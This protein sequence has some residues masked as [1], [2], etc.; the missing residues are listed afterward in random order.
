MPTLRY[1]YYVVKDYLAD[2]PERMIEAYDIA[3]GRPEWYRPMLENSIG[4]RSEQEAAQSLNYVKDVLKAPLYNQLKPNTEINSLKVWSRASRPKLGFLVI[5]RQEVPES[6]KVIS[7]PAIPIIDEDTFKNLCK[8]DEA[9]EKRG[10]T[11]YSENWD[12]YMNDM[13]I[14]GGISARKPFY[15]ASKRTKSNLYDRFRNRPTIFARELAGLFAAGYE[16]QSLFDKSEALVPPCDEIPREFNIQFY[17]ENL[18]K[19]FTSDNIG[20]LTHPEIKK[21]IFHP[22]QRE[23]PF[24]PVFDMWR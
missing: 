3:H 18:E 14:S 9:H 20:F 13:F 22:E 4:Y 7:T 17:N 8:I 16:L 15:L 5:G 11:L 23:N 21:F 24:E 10:S 1:R 19:F 6:G 2:T 12:F